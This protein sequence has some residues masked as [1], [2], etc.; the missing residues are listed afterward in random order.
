MARAVNRVIHTPGVDWQQRAPRRTLRLTA[1][2]AVAG[3]GVGNP[4]FKVVQ[5]RAV[6]QRHKQAVRMGAAPLLEFG[7][8]KRDGDKLVKLAGFTVMFNM[9][10]NAVL[11]WHGRSMVENGGQVNQF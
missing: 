8:F 10:G 7:G 11:C 1:Y 6:S 5:Q 3:A 9:G 4:R 2:V